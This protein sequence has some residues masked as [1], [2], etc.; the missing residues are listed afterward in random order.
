MPVWC[1]PEG[2]AEPAYLTVAWFS[3]S[4]PV[5]SWLCR[6]GCECQAHGVAK[7]DKVNQSFCPCCSNWELFW[8]LNLTVISA[9]VFFLWSVYSLKL[10]CQYCSWVAPSFPCF[11]SFDVFVDSNRM[12]SRSPSL[13]SYTRQSIPATSCKINSQFPGSSNPSSGL[14]YGLVIKRR[15]SATSPSGSLPRSCEIWIDW[16]TENK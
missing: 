16:S 6:D 5:C 1:L 13:P 11:Y 4:F 9:P 3:V 14:G 10:L 8:Q 12:P 15:A 2:S 7:A